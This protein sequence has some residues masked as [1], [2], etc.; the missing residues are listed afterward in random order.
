MRRGGILVHSPS[1]TQ[2][3]QEEA[4][5]RDGIFVPT[6]SP[7]PQRLLEEAGQ[8]GG[9][10]VPASSPP[11]RWNPMK[12][13]HPDYRAIFQGSGEALFAHYCHPPQQPVTAHHHH[14][15]NAPRQPFNP[16]HSVTLPAHPSAA[17]SSSALLTQTF[18]TAPHTSPAPHQPQQGL[19]RPPPGQIKE[20]TEGLHIINKELGHLR[21]L[22]DT[23][24]PNAP[25]YSFLQAL[26]KRAIKS[27]QHIPKPR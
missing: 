21:A 7:S 26:E 14:H 8:R 1:T 6:A 4:C 9:F 22:M 10:L 24:G 17:T 18:T 25:E 23:R 16:A 3:P 11:P 27:L 13:G 19:Q 2:R 15:L 20:Y 5:Q 12:D